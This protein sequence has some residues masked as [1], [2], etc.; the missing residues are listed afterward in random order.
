ML[1]RAL[2]GIEANAPQNKL[3]VQPVL[4][5]WLPDLELVNLSVGEAIVSLRFWRQDSQ[6]QDSRTQWEV[7]H[8]EGELQVVSK[9][10]NA[11]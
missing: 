9:E 10:P 5:D 3:I 4:P 11:K 7:T 6:T 2:L 1:I 8:L